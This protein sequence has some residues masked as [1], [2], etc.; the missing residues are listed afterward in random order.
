MTFEPEID[1]DLFDEEVEAE[2]DT[3][4]EYDKHANDDLDWEDS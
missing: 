4:E 2:T 3:T 1:E